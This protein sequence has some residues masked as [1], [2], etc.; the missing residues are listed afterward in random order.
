MRKMI[1]MILTV[2]LMLC[3][4]ACGDKY[5]GS[6]K[7]GI[8]TGSDL[9]IKESLDSFKMGEQYSDMIV[10]AQYAESI[11]EDVNTVIPALTDMASEEKTKVIIIVKAGEGT[12]EAIH[13]ARQMRDDILFI[14]VDCA[15]EASVIAEES[16]ICINA[17]YPEDIAEDEKPAKE[18]ECEALMLEASIAYAQKWCMGK[19]TADEGSTCSE[20]NLISEFE[21][22]GG[23]EMQISKY[24]DGAIGTLDNFYLIL[25]PNSGNT[26]GIQKNQ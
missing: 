18:A 3:V 5:D 12:A 16:D 21:N 11:S 9:Q 8:V 4:T 6:F 26:T 14:C 7:I 20:K 22:I 23:N 13:T 15:E 25:C 24:M 19:V 2:S 1:A 10:T 17:D